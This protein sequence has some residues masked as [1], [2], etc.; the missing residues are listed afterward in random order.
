MEYRK[1]AGILK[2]LEY[3][4]RGCVIKKIFGGDFMRKNRFLTL[5]LAI[6]MTIT[7]HSPVWG[8]SLGAVSGDYVFVED[9]T[10]TLLS[11]SY[12]TSAVS[13]D[14]GQNVSGSD[15]VLTLVNN[16]GNQ[17]VNGI[18]AKT[19]ALF[20]WKLSKLLLR[21]LLIQVCMLITEEV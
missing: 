15:I 21:V 18:E 9:S 2:D 5:Q 8:A 7:A 19:A 20:S 4:Q 11:G 17:Y 14:S 16:S 3:K 12:D 1:E 6:L 10:V 13:V